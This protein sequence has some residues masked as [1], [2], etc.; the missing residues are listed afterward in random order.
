MGRFII[1]EK[2]DTEPHFQHVVAGQYYFSTNGTARGK[3][4]YLHQMRKQRGEKPIQLY[5]GEIE[6]VEART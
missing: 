3:A 4:Q 2:R 5:V 6:K 1:L